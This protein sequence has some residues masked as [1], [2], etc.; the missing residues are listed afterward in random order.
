MDNHITGQCPHCK[1]E[2]RLRVHAAGRRARCKN[3]KQ[4]FIVPGE[5]HGASVD[6]DVVSWLHASKDDDLDE[7]RVDEDEEEDEEESGVPSTTGLS[8]TKSDRQDL[9]GHAP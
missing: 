8:S 4:V 5:Q 6:D 2:Y 9:R 3:C 7:V 1:S